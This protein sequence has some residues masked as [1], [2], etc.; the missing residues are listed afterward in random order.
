MDQDNEK[1]TYFLYLRKSTDDPLR[2]TQSIER[3]ECDMKK[4]AKDRGL[5]IKETFSEAKSAKAPGV[6]KAFYEMLARIEAGEANGILCFS[7]CRL[8]R[9][10]VD[11][12]RIQWLLQKGIIKSLQTF[13][14]EYLPKDNVLLL[15]L[16]MGS[17][18]QEILTL[19]ERVTSGLKNKLRKGVRPNCAPVGYLNTKI[20]AKGEN[21]IIP[22]PERFE[23]IR[24]AWD[25]MLT[26]RYTVPEILKIMNED[27]RFRT[28]KTKKLGGKELSRSALY[29][30]FTNIFYTGTNY[31]YNNE[32]H[33]NGQHKQMITLQEY[34]RVQEILGRKG[35]PRPTEH[36]FP[37]TGMIRCGDP[38]CG[39]QI[40]A[41]VQKGITYYHCT[42]KKK[43]Y[44]CP[45]KKVSWV[46]SDD[47]ELQIKAEIDKITLIPEF[48]EWARARIKEYYSKETEDRNNIYE[49]QHKTMVSC[50]KQLDKLVDMKLN[51]QV[52]DDQYNEK[53]NV[54]LLQINNMKDKLDNTHE[55]VEEQLKIVERAIDFTARAHANFIKGDYEVK[56]KI[57]LALGSN[58]I[59]KDKKLSIEDA[60]W[61]IPIKENYK[62][63]EQEY[64][65]FEL[66]ETLSVK[67]KEAALIPLRSTWRALRDSNPQPT[68]SKPGTLSVELKARIRGSETV[69]I[70]ITH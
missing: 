26:G 15:C 60:E 37:F 5:K 14:K 65:R 42:G 41:E 63:L 9:N 20:E 38:L 58:F 4:I 31:Y 68:G 13:D 51:D 44:K 40:T 30:I 29:R 49:T 61:L 3:Q 56:K 16:I 64:L 45:Q 67:E 17:A 19:S 47:L 59:L 7:P 12:G 18:T 35:K 43:D 6:R 39:C 10:P 55:R 46:R 70:I 8:S 27:W 24:K 57:L 53:R 23:L 21:Y 54:L 25:F 22:D 32:L 1:I 36:R 2:Q 28:K 33:T 69:L 11:G 34:D 48:E 66:D 52:T 50:Q 62:T